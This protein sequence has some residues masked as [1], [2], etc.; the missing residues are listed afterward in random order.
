MQITVNIA[1]GNA[2]QVLEAAFVDE[3]KIYEAYSK[4][5]EALRVF[6][7]SEGIATHI[8]AE[9]ESGEV[10]LNFVVRYPEAKG[11]V[12]VKKIQLDPVKV[13]GAAWR[14]VIEGW[15]LIQLQLRFGADGVVEVRVAVNSEKRAQAW[16]EN[17]LQMGSPAQWD[18]KVVEKYARRLIR[19]L[20]QSA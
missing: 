4:P 20:R 18:W 8:Q 7:N 9:R 3:A 15:G 10:F 2:R 13:K 1:E 19:A 5:D 11:H 14:E 12:D 6:E 16:A 17:Y